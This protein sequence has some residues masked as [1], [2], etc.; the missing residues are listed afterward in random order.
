M[1]NCEKRHPYIQFVG[2]TCP[3]CFEIARVTVLDKE[4]I[5]L[6]RQR[7]EATKDGKIIVRE[8]T[9]TKQATA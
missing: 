3:L 4:C 6:E 2:Q 8:E 7:D 5:R 9:V 1:N